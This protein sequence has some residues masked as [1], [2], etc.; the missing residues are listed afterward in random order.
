[1]GKINS[2]SRTADQSA[3]AKWWYEYSDIGWNRIARIQAAEYHPG[4]YTTARMFALLNKAIADGY[5]AG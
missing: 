1:V 3:Y 5:T 4:L 2:T